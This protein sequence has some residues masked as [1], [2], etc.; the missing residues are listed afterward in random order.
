MTAD[1]GSPFLES[2]G[3]YHQQRSEMATGKIKCTNERILRDATSLRQNMGRKVRSSISTRRKTEITMLAHARK[4]ICKDRWMKSRDFRMTDEKAKVVVLYSGHEDLRP[5]RITLENCQEIVNE[6]TRGDAPHKSNC[7]QQEHSALSQ[8]TVRSLKYNSKVSSSS[9]YQSNK[10]FPSIKVGSCVSSQM[11]MNRVVAVTDGSALQQNSNC[12][13]RDRPT[14][15]HQKHKTSSIFN[16]VHILLLLL[17]C[18]GDL[19]NTNQLQYMVMNLT[20][21]M[22]NVATFSSRALPS[23]NTGRL[24]SR[25]VG[26]FSGAEAAIIPPAW[27]NEQLNPCA[28][29]SWQLLYWPQHDKCYKIFSQVRHATNN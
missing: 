14:T 16:P 9:I 1:G 7:F 3:S 23:L 24:F 6:S 20:H 29:K 26:L 12:P 8:C 2:S 25:S 27:A 10:Q 18:T 21:N 5:T 19:F 15:V 17:A 13:E 4:F 22:A 11:L 28:R